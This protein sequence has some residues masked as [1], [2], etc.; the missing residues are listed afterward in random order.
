MKKYTLILVILCITACINIPQSIPVPQKPKP[1]VPQKITPI[2][3]G[4]SKK[5][6]EPPIL[7]INSGGH[8]AKIQ[9]IFFTRDG[10][11]LISASN[12]KTIRVWDIQTGKTV[13]M[14]RGQ[15][16]AGHEGKIYAAALSGDNQWL[17]VGGYPSRF[18]IRLIHFPT[19]QIK[20]LLKGHDNVILSLNFSSNN[21]RLISGSAD[22]TARI[23]DITSGNTLHT[24]QGHTD[25]IYAVA[26]SP[27]NQLAVT[28]SD[29]HTL[30]LWQVS[31]G[32]LQAT[33]EGHDDKVKSVA[34]TPY[35]HYILS[36]SDDKTIRLWNG[37]TG[38]FIKVM[39]RQNRTVDSLS[40]SLDGTVVLTGQ[41]YGNGDCINNIFSIPSGKS[42]STFTKHNNIVLATAIS[43]DGTTAAT[44]GGNDQ[45][46]WIWDVRTGR[47]IKKL[48]GNGKRVW[49]VG[50]SKD[51]RSIAWG[52]T[53]E[54]YNMF[55]YGP[56]EHSF[57]FQSHSDQFG[58][59]PGP[60][61]ETD[62]IRA[63]ENKGT[64]S[65]QTQNNKVHPTLEIL[66]NKSVKHRI[67][68]GS[69]DGN[70]HRSLT[71]SPD[72]R[73]VISGGGT[74]VLASYN[75]QTGK[76]EKE[77]IG[78]TGDVW[79]VAVSP[80]GRLLVSGSDDQT[81]RLWE[82]ATGTP[83]MTLFYGTDQEWVA[84][85]PEGFFASSTSGA[86]YVGY[87]LNRGED[88]PADYVSVD[89]LY[90]LFYRPDL[91]SQK[92][93]GDPDHKVETALDRIGN[94]DQVLAS[95]MPPLIEILPH[96]QHIQK[97]DFTLAFKISDAGGGIGKIEYRIDGVL[98][99]TNQ[100]VRSEPWAMARRSGVI[101]QPLSASDGKRQVS[102]TI[103]NKDNT[104]ASEEITTE[105][106]IDDPLKDAPD[107]YVL[108]IGISEY[109]E[110]NLQLKYAHHDATSIAKT[111]HDRGKGLFRNIHLTPLLDQKAVLPNIYKTFDRLSKTIKASDVFVLFIA[112]HG[113]VI[114]G[115]YYFIPQDALYENAD[116]F[117]K[118]ILSDEDL[119][120]QLQ[121]INAL[122]SLILIDTCFSAH[123]V[124][125]QLAR[126]STRSALEEKTALDRL[127][128]STGRT[129]L[130]AASSEQYAFEGHEGH[131]V[132]TY[133][134][135]QG[136]KGRADSN[137]NGLLSINE[138]CDFV[139]FEVP[140]ITEKK[141]KYPQ[142]PV[143]LTQ[144]DSFAI[145]CT[146][147]NAGCGK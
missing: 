133:A 48:V 102:V 94:I 17:A 91:V 115:N 93:K 70:S 52:N 98:V 46:I 144:G 105:V 73:L 145:G 87:H 71:L 2:K 57:I 42:I 51:G 82:V 74:G 126:A 7:Q 120:T 20:H 77:F 66:E 6:T 139:R 38:R 97:T 131:G 127:M 24:L 75:T 125:N 30:K 86:K 13:R 56:L 67:T 83:L 117:K 124:K 68:R 47:E 37:K 18:G 108:A 65:I 135:L 59:K 147:E 58:P 62:F 112:G 92:I 110:A 81:I 129:A 113:K 49:S 10:K 21:T 5:L 138:L 63:I 114:D 3:P 142:T 9:D 22:K 118:I 54:Q 84:W 116:L 14:L 50:F 103:Y 53:Y 89:Q 27:D 100:N 61:N 23:W 26:F 136:L 41:G 122:K 72:G 16:G 88:Q 60:I 29:D 90:A 8:M 39:A 69:T 134:L 55:G 99:A 45:E 15:I 96:A 132:F 43:P 35:G 130:A 128:R 119:V 123:L 146:E 137:H 28:G 140:K 44:G 104:I 79:G 101:R 78:H 40:V 76:K 109:K 85:T 25:Y 64:V 106:T 32:S 4:P 111:F 31:D 34:F 141:W 1:Q 143:R 11:Q 33:L 107:L 80:D 95:G 121:K 12:D 36:G 19:G